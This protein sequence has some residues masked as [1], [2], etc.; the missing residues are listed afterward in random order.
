MIAPDRRP[1]RVLFAAVAGTLL[2]AGALAL[3]EPRRATV[4]DMDMG[5]L[6][7]NLL[8]I[9]VCE[10]E[11]AI[12]ARAA[13]E[14]RSTASAP[15]MHPAPTTQSAPRATE[16]APVETVPGVIMS[17]D[18]RVVTAEIDGTIEPMSSSRCDE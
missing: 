7:R 11:A 15:S 10:K 4:E 3:E 5:L 17:R 9:Y 18:S 2:A 8:K 1:A 14:S 16:P 13:V 6:Q 12:N